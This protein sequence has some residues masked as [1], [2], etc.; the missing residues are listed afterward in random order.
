MPRGVFYNSEFKNNDGTVTLIKEYP[1][2]KLLG[3]LEELLKTNYDIDERL[4]NQVIYNFF[5]S[6]VLGYSSNMRDPLGFLSNL[7]KE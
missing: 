6:D 5:S 3:K 4:S 7:V 2:K 1:I